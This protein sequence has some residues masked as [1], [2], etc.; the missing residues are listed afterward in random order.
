M[1]RKSRRSPSPEK[2]PTDKIKKKGFRTDF[3]STFP[4]ALALLGV[5]V[6]CLAGIIISSISLEQSQ[7]PN[8]DCIK[9]TKTKNGMCNV[10]V[11]FPY[12]CDSSMCIGQDLR[13][14]GTIYGEEL[15]PG[16][17]SSC[18]FNPCA[19]LTCPAGKPG[20]NGSQGIPGNQGPAGENFQVNSFGV[21]DNSTIMFIQSQNL[22][23]MTLYFYLVTTDLRQNLNY[24]Q[25]LQMN[26]S[27]DIIA[28][29]GSVWINAG[30]LGGIVGP[31]GK[32]FQ[33]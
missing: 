28:Y 2:I 25:G 20:N 5:G 19:N 9:I 15:D 18:H 16:L 3:K 27:G 17:C 31:Q 12:P 8:K 23:G 32:L 26:T 1:K 10:G 30:E 7:L 22:T 14:Y 29:N 21:F 13:V 11:D 33:F 24:P 4:Y 6:L